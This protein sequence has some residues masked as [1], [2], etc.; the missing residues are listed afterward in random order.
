MTLR[1]TM[2]AIL[3]PV[4]ALLGGFTYQSYTRSQEIVARLTDAQS[5]VAEARWLY[6]AVHELQKERGYSAGYLSSNGQ[7]FAADLAAQ[8]VQSDHAVARLSAPLPYIRKAAPEQMAL[9]DAAMRDIADWR[10][11]VDRFDKTVSQMAGLYTGLIQTLLDAG[12]MGAPQMANS[13]LPDLLMAKALLSQAKENAGL[14]RA[15][16]AA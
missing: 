4:V 5:S 9:V 6:D 10:G 8:R 13:A 3:I 12:G 2:L 11:A 14:E 7:Q 15:M 16:G 1:L